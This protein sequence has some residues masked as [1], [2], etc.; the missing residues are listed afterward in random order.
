MK[1]PKHRIGDVLR[2]HPESRK[3]V[4]DYV[5]DAVAENLPKWI[6]DLYSE[7][8]QV[9]SMTFGCGKLRSDVDFNIALKKDISWLDYAHARRWYYSSGRE[10]LKR[11]LFE[12]EKK[13]GLQID[14]GMMD[15][16]TDVYNVYVSVPKMKLFHRTTSFLDNFKIGEVGMDCEVIDPAPI[17]LITFNPAVD[18]VPPALDLH[19]KWDGY[20]LRWRRESAIKPWKAGT[21]WAPSEEKWPDEIAYWQEYYGDYFQK[22]QRTI[23]Q[24]NDKAIEQLVPA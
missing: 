12:Y 6:L 9:G 2:W 23:V 17:D 22:Y 4:Y 3:E 21:A 16:E 5:T 10:P 8:Q 24:H 19:L 15:V 13:F 1:H 7:L 20:Y 14:L 11:R 18:P